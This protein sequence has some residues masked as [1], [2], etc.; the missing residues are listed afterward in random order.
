[1]AATGAAAWAAEVPMVGALEAAPLPSRS[2]AKSGLNGSSFGNGVDAGASPKGSSRVFQRG[3][4]G[5]PGCG[6]LAATG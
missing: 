3:R 2:A 1:M 4:S 5:V 6:G